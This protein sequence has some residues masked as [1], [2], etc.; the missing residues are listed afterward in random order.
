M[1]RL[2]RLERVKHYIFIFT[3]SK[4]V[5]PNSRD[6]VPIV[7]WAYRNAILSRDW[8][9]ARGPIGAVVGR[10]RFLRDFPKIT[11]HSLGING[12]LYLG[13]KRG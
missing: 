8:G 12:A 10:P 9:L 4:R 2:T 13:A 7:I 1:S 5:R 11:D 3:A 6:P